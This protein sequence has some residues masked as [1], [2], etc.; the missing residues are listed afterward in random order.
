[1]KC[2]KEETSPL[3]FERS[4]STLLSVL[5]LF[6]FF[7]KIQ[8]KLYTNYNKIK[9]GS[10]QPKQKCLIA[11]Q[12][13]VALTKL[14]EKVLEDRNNVFSIKVHRNLPKCILIE[15]YFSLGLKFRYPSTHYFLHEIFICIFLIISGITFQGLNFI[16][17][18]Y[19]HLKNIY[20]E[21]FM[22]TFFYAAQ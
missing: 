14:N 18:F 2:A 7:L 6:K 19:M 12:L 20:C 1:M 13:F 16:I 4:K 21:T 5:S 10:T 3:L 15:S 22:C 8:W 17:P 9:G 11:L